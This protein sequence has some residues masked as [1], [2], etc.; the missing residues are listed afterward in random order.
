[1]VKNDRVPAN[2][3]INLQVGLKQRLVDKIE[4]YLSKGSSVWWNVNFLRDKNFSNRFTFTWLEL[5]LMES[6]RVM[7]THSAKVTKCAVLRLGFA[8]TDWTP[9]WHFYA[10]KS[11]SGHDGDHC[12]RNTHGTILPSLSSHNLH[13]RPL[14]NMLHPITWPGWRNMGTEKNRQPT[15]AGDDSL[16]HLACPPS[17]YCL[18]RQSL[19]HSHA[20][21]CNWRKHIHHDM[22]NSP[23]RPCDSP[24][25]IDWT[26][27]SC[28]WYCDSTY[29]Y[30]TCTCIRAFYQCSFL[31]PSQ[32]L[33]SVCSK[34]SCWHSL[35]LATATRI[36]FSHVQTWHTNTI[37]AASALA[38]ETITSTSLLP[39][40]R[41]T[42]HSIPPPTPAPTR[43]LPH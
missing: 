30:I 4:C 14:W 19:S 21:P 15:S 11:K 1:M 18:T 31:G 8:M 26:G 2:H 13:S 5:Y 12:S 33:F 35:D 25:L 32:D 6:P 34:Q 28:N 7:W 38:R 24:C 40:I 43:Q 16:P 17:R 20:T 9:S 27:Q 3:R 29:I 23:S 36:S 41:T 42:S 22:V 39:H 10:C 37:A